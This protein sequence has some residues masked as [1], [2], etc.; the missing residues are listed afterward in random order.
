MF[1]FLKVLVNNVHQGPVTEDFPLKP[2]HTPERYRGRVTVD[3]LKCVGC[4]VCRHVCSGRAIRIE[5][6]KDGEGYEFTIWHNS[7][8]MC[9]ACHYYC[10]T[11]AIGQTQDWHSAHRQSEKYTWA[12]HRVIPY[13]PCAECGAHIRMLPAPI[14]TRLFAH[15]PLDMRSLMTL[16]PNCRKKATAKRKGMHYARNTNPE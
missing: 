12:E 5:D 10:P 14:A 4:R 8:C 2:A 7:C 15:S 3:P 6:T 16:C 13:R 9:G 1:K 11:G